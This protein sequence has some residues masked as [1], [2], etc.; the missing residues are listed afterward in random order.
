MPFAVCFSILLHQIISC[1]K[2]SHF[3]YRFSALDFFLFLGVA[4]FAA[5]FYHVAGKEK[6]ISGVIL[7]QGSSEKLNTA[8]IF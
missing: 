5:V 3:E 6:L 2:R 1:G 8:R 4:L 7:F